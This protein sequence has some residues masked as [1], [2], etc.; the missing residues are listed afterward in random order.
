MTSLDF[1]YSRFHIR[2]AWVSRYL[3]KSLDLDNAKAVTDHEDEVDNSSGPSVFVIEGGL[4][5][6]V[7]TRRCLP[8]PCLCLIPYVFDFARAF[9]RVPSC[10]GLWIE[11]LSLT[12]FSVFQNK[13]GE[14][15]QINQK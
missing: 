5:S 4:W 14:N 11:N 7:S 10:L 13:V 2:T 3:S 6:L 1:F 15:L 12:N 9:A 8:L